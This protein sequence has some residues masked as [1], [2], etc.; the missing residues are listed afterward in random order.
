[1]N[2]IKIPLGSGGCYLLL[3]PDEWQRGIARGKRDRRAKAN[4]KQQQSAG[5][6]AEVLDASRKNRDA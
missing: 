1:M 6:L 2:L 4:E 5:S 3:T